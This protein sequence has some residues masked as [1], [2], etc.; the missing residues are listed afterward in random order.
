MAREK[1]DYRAIMEQLNN[2]FPDKFLLTVTDVASFLGVCRR[3]VRT[4]Y[5]LPSGE[6]HYNKAELARMVAR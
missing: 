3:T 2:K 6:H 5:P 1:E 4:R